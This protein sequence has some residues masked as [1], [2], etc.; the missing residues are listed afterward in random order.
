MFWRKNQASFALLCLAQ[1][2]AHAL[3]FPSNNLQRFLC[4]LAN[5]SITITADGPNAP[6][7]GDFKGVVCLYLRPNGNGNDNDGECYLVMLEVDEN[8]VCGHKYDGGFVVM[9]RST[10]ISEVSDCKLTWNAESQEQGKLTV[11]VVFDK[12]D[13]A[14]DFKA[15]FLA[16]KHGAT[17]AHAAVAAASSTI[18]SAK[19]DDD[20]TVGQGAVGSAAGTLSD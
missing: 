11:D 5:A 3:F 19:A 4:Q 17:T 2:C 14:N 9:R 8:A 1:Y 20:A 18:G 12:D 15:A 6:V 13:G 16:F 7:L 10:E